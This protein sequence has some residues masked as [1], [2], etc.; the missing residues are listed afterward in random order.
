MDVP[1]SPLALRSMCAMFKFIDR[2]LNQITMYRLVLYFL[3]ALLGIGVIFSGVGLLPY[4]PFA[5]LLSIGLIVGIC[6]VV[7]FIFAKVYNVPANVESVYISALI[8]ALII[9][10]I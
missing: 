6:W 7:N 4:S 9:A 8:L 10:P 2:W 3:I 5:M 1:R